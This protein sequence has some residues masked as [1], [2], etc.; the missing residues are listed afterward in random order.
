MKFSKVVLL[1]AAASAMVF[2]QGADGNG[3]KLRFSGDVLINSAFETDK[4]YEYDDNYGV[5]NVLLS[6]E[7]TEDEISK[8]FNALY[9]WNVL[10]GLDFGDNFSVDF[11][12][13][14]QSGYGLDL[15]NFENGSSVLDHIPVLP[16]AYFTWRQ[17]IFSLKGGLLEVSG[18]T[19]LD[20]VAGVESGA[21]LWTYYWGW[22]CEYNASQGG[23]KLGFDLSE[24]FALNLTAALVSPTNTLDDDP[25]YNEFR[26]ILDADIAL[27]DIITLTPVFQ[28]RSF[29][30][31]GYYY[32]NINGELTIED[33]TPLL[34]AY[35]ADV[36]LALSDNFN[37]DLGV[38]A[39][40]GTNIY[41]SKT[42]IG[43][44][45]NE[46][47]DGRFGLLA[48]VA[49]SFTFGI[50]E[51]AAQYSFGM[52]TEKSKTEAEGSGIETTLT[53]KN[54]TIY[55]DI[56]FG[57]FL[58]VHDNFAFGPSVNLALS[59]D[60]FRNKYET[61]VPNAI[62]YDNDGNGEVYNV[63]RFGLEFVASF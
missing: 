22:D 14:N 56:Y 42:E 16:N 43:P 47:K 37:I 8:T 59:S 50:N 46:R 25:I 51:I 31:Q 13:S 19:A 57:Y 44:N 39:G 20:L 27:G 55:N 18:N 61:N 52:L 48:K 33:K 34:L 26:C 28:A 60:K 12:L 54:K 21:G 15:L 30:R 63:M 3:P 23:I 45:K 1:A 53:R 17:G 10:F 4:Y 6:Q 7:K 36:G 2:A 11:R 41:Y 5:G 29:W 24:S 9:G 49:P 40:N 62:A 38:A 58:R 35:G 32:E